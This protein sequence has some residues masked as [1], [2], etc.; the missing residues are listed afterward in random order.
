MAQQAA[1][2]PNPNEKLVRVFDTEQ[3][4]EAFVVQGLLESGGIDSQI[5]QHENSPDVLP[6]GGISIL[7]REEDAAEARQIIAEFRRSPEQEQAEEDAFDET[8]VDATSENTSE[9]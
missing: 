8:A 9:Q 5:G 4:S 7:V 2:L 6:V 1:P 3:E